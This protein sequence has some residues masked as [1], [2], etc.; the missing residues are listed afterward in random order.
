MLIHVEY[1]YLCKW[2]STTSKAGLGLR[3]RGMYSIYRYIPYLFCLLLSINITIH[4][5]IQCIE[6]SACTVH[7][8]LYTCDYY[9][10]SLVAQPTMLIVGDVQLALRTLAF[11]TFNMVSVHY[12]YTYTL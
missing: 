5:I 7:M 10:H 8:R 1:R 2:S 9:K 12:K 4:T 3:N 6:L 11:K